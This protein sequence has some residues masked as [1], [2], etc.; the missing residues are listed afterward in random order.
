VQP[1]L[2]L[3]EHDRRIRLEDLRRHLLAAMRGQAVHEERARLG[4]AITLRHLKRREH[5]TANV[6]FHFLAID[7]QTSV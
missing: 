1:V 4:R 5:G 7:A 3:I 2:G 6:G